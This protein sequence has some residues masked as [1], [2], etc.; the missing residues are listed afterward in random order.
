[1]ALEPPAYQPFWPT[2]WCNEQTTGIRAVLAAFG[3]IACRQPSTWGGPHRLWDKTEGCPDSLGVI[4]PHS[5]RS[6]DRVIARTALHLTGPGQRRRHAVARNLILDRSTISSAYRLG[7]AA[8]VSV[9]QPSTIF[10]AVTFRLAKNQPVH[11]SP[12]RL[13]RGRRKQTV[14]REMICL[15]IARLFFRDVDL[16]MIGRNNSVASVVFNSS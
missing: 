13:P 11:S 3:N 6:P 9:L 12:V 14:F 10:V 16:R 8:P 5:M 7:Q 15:T 4:A 1:M 2:H